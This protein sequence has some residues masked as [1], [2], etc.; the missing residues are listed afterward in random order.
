MLS[1]PPSVVGTR[2]KFSQSFPRP[3]IWRWKFTCRLR[4]GKKKRNLTSTHAGC[5]PLEPYYRVVVVYPVKDQTFDR[6]CM[7]VL[8]PF[9]FCPFHRSTNFVMLN[10][11][12]LKLWMD[13]AW[14]VQMTESN[15]KH[16]IQNIIVT[17]WI[18]KEGFVNKI[19]RI[20]V[21]LRMTWMMKV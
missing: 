6:N 13:I 11:T 1:S 7:H 18:R 9:P 14:L 19:C 2:T 21:I 17:Q 3:K 16:I 4:R 12:F 15:R 5:I 8:I 20:T 10:F